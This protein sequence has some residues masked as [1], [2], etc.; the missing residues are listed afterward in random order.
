MPGEGI[1]DRK[2]ERQAVLECL[3]E[4]SAERFKE[5]LE[6]LHPSDIA[7]AFPALNLS[8][9]V[10]ILRMMEPEDAAQVVYDLERDLVVPLMEGL[11]RQRTARILEEMS[12][13]DAADL[14]GELPPGEKERLLGIMAAADARDVR[15]LLA[16]G[17]ETAGGIMTTEYV[18]VEK[19]LT[20][21]QAIQVLRETAQEAE[22]IYY[23]YVVN[24]ENQ[25]VGVF[26]LRDLIMA[27]PE[28]PVQEIMHT[29]VISVNVRTDQEEVARLVAKYDLLAIPVVSDHQEILGIVT[30]DDV[31][32]VIE[33]E[34]TEDIMRLAANIDLEGQDFEAGAW[35]R[36][37]KRLPWLVGLLFGEL[38]AGN[39]IKNYSGAL[40]AM[41][42][43][44][45]F[46]TIMAGG[47]GNAATQSLAVVVR[48]LATG[49]VEPGEILKVIW[50]ETRVG[51][52][53]G[54]ISGLVMAVTATLWQGLPL[55]GLVVGLSLA[56]SIVAATL[57]GSFFPVVIHRLGI[58]PALASGPLITTLMD[59]TSMMIYFGLATMLLLR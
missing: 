12:D 25:L 16:Y 8:Q 15:M 58:D 10:K 23:V 33:E 19:E 42:M 32:D 37:A 29:R 43:L 41:T 7:D 55:L 22:T 24:R 18:A 40:E 31:L 50:K 6:N 36:A 52:L 47:P 26:S 57:L 59:I 3:G 44:A 35:R 46:I 14:L 34:A 27:D 48:G 54:L 53:V 9:R 1:R 30:V 49:E 13:D 51:I 21:R 38:M 11:G 5:C 17:A 28:A 2:E 45:F 39:V 56:V 4:V 20:A